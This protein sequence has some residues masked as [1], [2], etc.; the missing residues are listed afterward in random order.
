MAKLF[1]EAWWEVTIW[2]CRYFPNKNLGLRFDTIAI[3]QKQN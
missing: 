3:S 1:P 2:C